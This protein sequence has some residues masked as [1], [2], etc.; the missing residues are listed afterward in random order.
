VDKPKHKTVLLIAASRQQDR[1]QLEFRLGT[2]S[3]DS[4]EGVPLATFELR[5]LDSI[6][7]STEFQKI[8]R[9]VV[10]TLLMCDEPT[11]LPPIIHD[12]LEEAT[13]QA[14]SYLRARATQSLDAQF[15][16][17]MHLAAEAR[18][19]RSIL[20]LNEANLLLENLVERKYGSAIEWAGSTWPKLKEE[21]LRLIRNVGN[22]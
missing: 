12:E 9:A 3:T 15:H 6:N 2:P 8:G 10:I 19:K 4:P 16:L 5:D 13:V 1:L 18:R 11:V 7:S 21:T 20:P 14:E 22:S 17:V